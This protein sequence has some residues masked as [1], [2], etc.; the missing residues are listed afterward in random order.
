MGIILNQSFQDL[1]QRKIYQN[2]VLSYLPYPPKVEIV[3]N[4]SFQDHHTLSM[5]NLS[6]ISSYKTIKLCYSENYKISVLKRPPHP[7]KTEII[8][9]QSFEDAT[10]SK[11]E[12]Y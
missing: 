9:N 8:Q 5:Y 7:L 6:K 4:E 3:A 2:S 12:N 10:S 11:S 1:S